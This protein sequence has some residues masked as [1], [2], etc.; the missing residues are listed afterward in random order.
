MGG[1]ENLK[2]DIPVSS[3]QVRFEGI[4]RTGGKECHNAHFEKAPSFW[5]P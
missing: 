1:W 5:K 3:Q 2:D 4:Q